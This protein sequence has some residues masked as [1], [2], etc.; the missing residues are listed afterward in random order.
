[1]SGRR[2]VLRQWWLALA[3]L[4]DGA[5]V[6]AADPPKPAITVFAASS[7]TDAMTELGND[8][9]KSTGV[10]VTL[11]FAASSALARQIETGAP[12]DVFFSA[13][14]DW[15]DYL[16]SRRLIQAA[17]RYDVV[18]NR[19]VLIAPADAKVELKIAPCF[20]LAAALGNG[21]LSTGDPDSVPVGRYA[22]AALTALGVW[23]SVADRLVRADNVRVALAFVA[24]G[25]APLGIV[26]ATDVLV[27]KRVRIVDVFPADSHAPI[28][29]PIALTNTAGPDAL[30][31]VTYLRGA[32]AAA[33]FRK[34]GFTTP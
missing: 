19:L 22:R 2:R 17:T 28:T 32:A 31:F 3:L 24:R 1:M 5:A 8:F 14:P 34:Y 12:A 21:R 13:D 30:R 9:R 20:A 29:Y 11:S 16:Q 33:T 15:M 6:S 10:A 4:A 25:E 7:L 23:E 27:E 18:G 26:Y